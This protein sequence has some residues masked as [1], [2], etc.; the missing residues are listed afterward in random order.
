MKI[1]VSHTVCGCLLALAVLLPWSVYAG[2]LEEG[3]A[4]Y[5]SGEYSKAVKAF[6][7]A[8][9]QGNEKAMYLL[10]KMYFAG[11]GV[12]HDYDMAKEYFTKAARAGDERSR[13]ELMFLPRRKEYEQLKDL[14]QREKGANDSFQ[15]AERGTPNAQYEL[16]MKFYKGKDGFPQDYVSARKWFEQAAQQG[17]RKAKKVLSEMPEDRAIPQPPKGYFERYIKAAESGGPKDKYELAW[18]FY[19]GAGV[20]K[21]YGKAM[22]WFL[23]SAEGGYVDAQLQVASMLAAGKGVEKDPK[24]AFVWCQRAADGGD[25]KAIEQLGYEYVRGNIVEKDVTKGIQLLESVAKG[26]GLTAASAANT[27]G[28]EYQ[29]PELHDL[30]KAY[31]WLEVAVLKGD[32][33]SKRWRDVVGVKIST[34]EIKQ[35]KQLAQ[36]WVQE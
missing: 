6:R 7:K 9:D 21:D 3:A 26:D 5:R 36:E 35:A 34:E 14:H 22:E 19:D 17:H 28:Y 24:K 8:A 27:L 20:S 23:L 10:G 32:S 15:A 1:I 16:G 31:M 13:Q 2:S 4:H 29:G 30:V 12:P 18:K 33:L 11:R 25:P